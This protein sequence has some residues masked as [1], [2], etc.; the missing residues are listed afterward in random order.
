MSPSSITPTAYLR[1]MSTGRTVTD[2]QPELTPTPAIRPQYGRPIPFRHAET[3]WHT[4]PV[5]HGATLEGPHPRRRD[6]P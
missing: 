3:L 6:T 5:M 4:A 2:L 1:Y